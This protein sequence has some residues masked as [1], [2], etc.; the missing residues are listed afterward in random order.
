MIDIDLRDL[1]AFD[2]MLA[3]FP[4]RVQQAASMAINQTAKREALGRVR[5][6]MRKQINWK[7][8]YLSDPKKTGIGKLASRTRLEATIYARDRP[9]MLNRFRPN[10]NLIPAKGKQQ[11]GVTVRVK[12]NNTKVLRKAFVVALGKRKNSDDVADGKRKNIAVMM[13]TKGGASEPPKGITHGGGRYISSMR[14]WLLYAP[15]I[16]QV[17]QDTAERNA[18]KIAQYLQ[19]EFL[20]QF[21]RLGK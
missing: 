19:N 1:V 10:P 13:R 7:E 17:M 15:S 21:E 6:D 4:D 14:A 20:R 5:R 9:T 11:R 16:D 8:S 3:L 18:D 12:P 2:E